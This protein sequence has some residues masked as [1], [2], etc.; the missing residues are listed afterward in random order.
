LAAAQG[1]EWIR[2]LLMDE[3]L[4]QIFKYLVWRDTKAATLLFIRNK[5]VTAVIKK[6]VDMIE[7]HP[8]Y[9]RTVHTSDERWDLVMRASDD[10]QREI[11]LAF[12]PFA[13]RTK[14]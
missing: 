14:S 7:A 4:G 11:K 9:K 1:E 6:A 13:L 12:I 3:A 5:D 8:N 10:E 2:D